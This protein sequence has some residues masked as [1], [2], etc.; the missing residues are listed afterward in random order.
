MKEAAA[1]TTNLL[2]ILLGLGL[3]FQVG[4][5]FEHAVQFAVWVSG[6]YRWVSVN[7]C[8]RGVP[9]MSPPATETVRFLGAR[10]FAG[11][12]PA[13][14][15]MVGMEIL[16]LI[17]NAIFLATIAGVFCLFPVRLVRYAFCIEGAHMCEHVPLTIS[18]YLIGKPIGL[19][20]LFG[21]AQSLWGIEAAV[22]WR[23]TFHFVMNLLPMPFVMVALMQQWSAA[24][25]STDANHP[26]IVRTQLGV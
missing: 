12:P 1:Q 7:F 17:G 24:G 15:M 2:V 21:H 4:H 5:F 22:G 25:E 26:G 11:E 18:A 23:V 10:L 8:G 16:H 3:A 14:Q 13:S 20:T 6:D 9:Y 19:S